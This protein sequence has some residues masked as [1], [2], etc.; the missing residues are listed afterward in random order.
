MKIM[1]NN[2]ERVVENG[3]LMIRFLAQFQNFETENYQLQFQNQQLSDENLLLRNV[4]QGIQQQLFAAEATITQLQHGKQHKELTV[5]TKSSSCLSPNNS[6]DPLAEESKQ[7]P[8]ITAISLERIQKQVLKYVSEDRHEMAMLLCTEA[9]DELEWAC[10]HDHPDVA[11]ILNTLAQ[12]YRD[13]CNYK[14]ARRLLNDVLAI[15]EKTLGVHP[16]VVATLHHLTVLYENCGNSQ[17][18]EIFCS[19]ALDTQVRLVGKSH[20][21]VAKNFRDLA[22]LCQNQLKFDKANFYYEQALQ[23]YETVLGPDDPNA[24]ATRDNF[25]IFYV[26]QGKFKEAEILYKTVLTW[27]HELKFG[28]IADDNKTIW[29]MAEQREVDKGISRDNTPYNLYGSWHR[30][31]VVN[32]STV[33]ETL[34]K[35]GTLYRNQGK[36]AAASTLEKRSTI[37]DRPAESRSLNEWKCYKAHDD[38]DDAVVSFRTGNNQEPHRP[39][40]RRSGRSY[41]GGEQRRLPVVWCATRS[42]RSPAVG[43]SGSALTRLNIGAGCARDSDR[44]GALLFSGYAAVNC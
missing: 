16:D 3:E 42:L 13:Q 26:T 43:R 17:E 24:A 25:A 4:L 10:G 35:L 23:I 15:R 14:E 11:T 1:N 28:P 41:P 5:S 22:L 18:A 44:T 27:V 9:V 37:V 31:D 19:K 34:I 6:P 7:R 30:I 40:E 8:S 32:T 38:D 39:S 29:Q 36:H 12:L 20:P 2:M 33:Q 21:D